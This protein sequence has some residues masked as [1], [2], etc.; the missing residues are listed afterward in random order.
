MRI[1]ARTIAKETSHLAIINGIV[2]R[3]CSIL[4]DNN[5]GDDERF[6]DALTILF[7]LDVSHLRKSDKS[8]IS[9]VL[10]NLNASSS[11]HVSSQRIRLNGLLRIYSCIG[12]EE[13]EEEK[14]EKKEEGMD[15]MKV[16][17]FAVR[18]K[19]RA[20]VAMADAL[21]RDDSLLEDFEV[22]DTIEPLPSATTT[23]DQVKMLFS[24]K[25]DNVL[26]QSNN[27]YNTQLQK[28]REKI[29]ELQNS[30]TQLQNRL[31]LEQH[32]LKKEKKRSARILSKFRG[33]RNAYRNMKTKLQ[34]E[35]E[36]NKR[37]V[38]N[39][40][41]RLNEK[42]TLSSSRHDDN[43]KLKGIITS[44]TLYDA[45]SQRE[46][47]SHANLEQFFATFSYTY[48]FT[49]SATIPPRTKM[50]QIDLQTFKHIL[51]GT[52]R[53]NNVDY[54]TFLHEH[55]IPHLLNVTDSSA[56][57]SSSLNNKNHSKIIK[58]NVFATKRFSS[59][60]KSAFKFYVSESYYENSSTSKKKRDAIS[61]DQCR[62][63]FRDFRI[64]PGLLS[65]R[66]V[67]MMLFS[68]HGSVSSSDNVAATIKYSSVI[69]MLKAIA[70]EAF[71]K[72]QEGKQNEALVGW[73]EKSRGFEK[74]KLLMNIIN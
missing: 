67:N 57:S 45:M 73:M 10:M 2:P 72:E 18:L 12:E 74:V 51:D 21:L 20:T 66:Q 64:S 48:P 30:E 34:E 40:Q 32:E 39:L 65:R 42:K 49:S 7:S 22:N 31:I 37:V 29:K 43:G 25:Q 9:S 62:R 19:R 63:F 38:A 46:T 71:P 41:R 17:K 26:E 50:Q 24:T 4:S 69:L 70:K 3:I 14:E 58:R 56:V 6:D 28:L 55:A 68:D 1:L 23:P 36:R 5:V 13:E 54:A 53:S 8:A 27:N 59:R 60:L 15:M 61:Q 33:V 16:A 35:A 52:L 11:M 44:S 47:L